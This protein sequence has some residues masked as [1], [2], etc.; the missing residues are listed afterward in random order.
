[1]IKLNLKIALRNLFK[2]KV[3]TFLNIGGLGIALAAFIVVVLYV[4]YETSYNKGIED[5][6]R[7]Y[8]VGR[9]LPDSKTEFTPAPLAGLIKESFPEVEMAGRTRATPFEFPINSEK[10]RVYANNALQLD[11]EAAKMLHV[12]P[13]TGLIQTMGMG[14]EMYIN[15]LVY[16]QLFP[17]QKLKF[18]KLVFLGPKQAGQAVEIRGIYKTSEEHTTIKHDVIALGKDIGFGDKDFRNNNFN[19]YIKIKKG[20]DVNALLIKID[21]RYKDELTKAG[22]PNE[23][24]SANSIFLDQLE[25]LHLKPSAGSNINYKIVQILFVLSILLLAIACINFT[26]LIIAQANSRAKE[27]G[28]KKVLGVE[29][30]AL[31]GQFLLEIGIQCFLALLIGLTIAELTIPLFNNL[32]N[33]PLTLWGSYFKLLLLL[34]A[35]LVTIIFV[36]GFYPAWVLSGFKPVSILKGNLQ[37]SIKTQWLR[38]ALLVGQFCI[39]IIFIAGLLIVSKQLKFMRTEDV[40]FKVDQVVHIKNIQFYNKP[41]EFEAARAKIEKIPGV[42]FVTV[43]SSIPGDFKTDTYP[44]QIEGKES[45]LNALN[46]D[47]DYFETLGAK[48]VS[49]RFFSRKLMADT[50]N[51]AV[52]N[53]S[54]VAQLKLKDPVGKQIK[55]CSGVYTIVGVVKDL[56][57]QGFEKAVDPTI[58]AIRNTCANTKIQIL[59]NINSNRMKEVLSTLKAQWST[60][61]TL[62][63]EDF[64]YDFLNQ[65]Y[66]KLFK[67]QEQLQ[68]IFFIGSFLTIGI[69][70][71][72]LFA[73]AAFTVNHRLKEISVR[74]I[75]GA[76]S[77][78]LY[79]LLN[80]FF[81]KVVLL[82]NL[83]AWPIIYVMASKWLNFFAYRIDL[84]ILPF[85][86]AGVAS[87][88]LSIITVSYQVYRGLK[89]NP[90]T[91]LKYE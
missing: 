61:N 33:V 51:S 76:T 15:P 26:N 25:D 30:K 23:I 20:T 34:T 3:Y 88:L 7:I 85:I 21:K 14:L 79:G 42:N 22:I 54:A 71:L 19:T 49:G 74:K 6:D 5:Y 41:K 75:L 47:F 9:N 13:D 55:G 35:V 89:I 10:G 48:L 87:T 43:A 63:G 66:G 4:D 77:F 39:S 57:T 60:I 90:S 52:L 73:F 1:M 78:Q 36:A 18:P 80:S 83:I 46:V 56:K 24:K 82:A 17:N 44:Y 2:N 72:G 53:E 69:A 40:G 45:V 91:V 62:D 58:F 29:R 31:I 38:N 28:V 12:W 70:L 16:S 11:H 64:R 59:V 32:F 68:A 8:L 86:I 67:Q 37:T 50:A 27:V 81:L 65:L 84:P